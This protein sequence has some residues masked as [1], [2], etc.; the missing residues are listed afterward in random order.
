M[1]TEGKKCG[2]GLTRGEDSLGSFTVSQASPA[3]VSIAQTPGKSR[4]IPCGGA[5]DRRL[6]WEQEARTYQGWSTHPS[7]RVGGR[8]GKREADGCFSESIVQRFE[9]L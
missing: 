7:L 3:F 8:E 9:T 2:M 6:R 1:G 5:D 4:R